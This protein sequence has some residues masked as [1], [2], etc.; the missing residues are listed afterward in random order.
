MKRTVVATLFGLLFSANALSET[1]TVSH[2]LGKTTLDTKPERVVVIGT[3][4]LDALDY[5]GIKPVALSKATTMPDYLL[6]YKAKEFA[7]SGSLN[8]PDF[9]TIYMQK[10]DVIIIGSR[11]AESYKELS[12]IAPTVMFAPESNGYWQSTQKQWR[13]LADIF[14]IQP[15][16]EAKIASVD[17]LISEIA[18]Y[19][20]TNHVK[21]LTVMSAGGNIT[22]F[23][24]QSRFSAIYRDFG[25]QEAVPNIKESRH[26][27]LI[28]Y[29]FISNVNPA[30]LFIIDKDKLINKD[31]SRTREEFA[32]PLVKSTTAYKNN[33][34]N[35]L[36]INAWYIA[37]S[38]VT[39]TDKMIQDMQKSRAL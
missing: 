30:N 16:V 33:N 35:Y 15:K 21:A 13:M 3:G 10:P 22:T 2:Q 11:A 25:F 17:S 1:I 37:L 5:F 23:G 26:G 12:K 27:D 34:L 28:S 6:K 29:E 24:A 19:N 39:A 36:D 38:G 8:E 18:N 14:E 7:S 4:T 9:E 32:N 20:K 31:K